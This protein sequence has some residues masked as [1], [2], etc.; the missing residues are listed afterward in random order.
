[1][2]IERRRPAF[3]GSDRAER[4]PDNWEELKAEGRRRNPQQVCHVCGLPGGT[5]FDHKDGDW[6]NNDQD[7]LDWIHSWR[8]VKANR[9]KRNC[10]GK[11]TG[12]E[13]AA[14]WAARRRRQRPEEVHPALR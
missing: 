12:A 13:G 11:K 1:M 4:L 2:A 3:E 14:A 9:S 5:D 8:D 10:H 6:Q 7:N